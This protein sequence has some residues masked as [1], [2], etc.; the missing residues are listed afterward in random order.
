MNQKVKSKSSVFLYDLRFL[1]EEYFIR[2]IA[3]TVMDEQGR[4]EVMNP[5]IQNMEVSFQ[6]AENTK[7]QKNV[8]K[9][10]LSFIYLVLPLKKR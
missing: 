9:F 2:Q 10:Q 5:H 3:V 7:I 8:K 4:V 6:L 1:R